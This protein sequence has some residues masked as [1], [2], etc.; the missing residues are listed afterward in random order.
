MGHAKALLSLE[1]RRYDDLGPNLSAPSYPIEPSLST[2][3][4]IRVP[5]TDLQLS[6][7]PLS[8]YLDTSTLS[9]EQ[10]KEMMISLHFKQ[11]DARLLTLKSAQAKTCRWMLKSVFYRD[12]MEAE[13]L[14]QH[15]GFFWIKGKPGA[16]K[17]IMMKFLFSEAKRTMKGALVLS[18]FFNARGEGFEKSTAGYI[19][20]CFYSSW[21]R[22]QK[23]GEFSTTM[24]YLSRPSKILVGRTRRSENYSPCLSSSLEI[25]E[26][27]ASWML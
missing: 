5:V 14:D 6:P 2:G 18:F 11:R 7:S 12:W 4:S 23:P 25:S 9:D 21:R 8:S 19:V 15:R 27:S 26:L 13:K 1:R 22:Y 10:R 20:R 17:S 24:A 3:P 16:G